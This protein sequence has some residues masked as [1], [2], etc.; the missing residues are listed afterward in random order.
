MIKN[1]G[2]Y[3]GVGDI[4]DDWHAR[5]SMKSQNNILLKFLKDGT[6]LKR[7][8]WIYLDNLNQNLNKFIEDSIRE[9]TLIKDKEELLRIGY[10]VGKYTDWDKII[11]LKFKFNDEIY[12]DR[13]TIV[14]SDVILNEKLNEFHFERLDSK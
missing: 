4:Y 3:L 12:L 9:I 11:E 13:Y 10:Q 14:S 1:N 8:Q 6:V 2:Y 5:K 7:N